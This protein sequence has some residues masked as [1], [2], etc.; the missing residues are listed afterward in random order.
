MREVKPDP[1]K[2][3]ALVKMSDKILERVKETD[4]E[5]F[6]SQVL[7]DYYDAIRQLM[8]A[9]ACLHGVNGVSLDH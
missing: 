8:E 4:E 5:R 2:A 3:K 6:P 9:I 7:R 1:D